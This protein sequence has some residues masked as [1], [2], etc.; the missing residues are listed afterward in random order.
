[1]RL[2]LLALC[3]TL[4]FSSVFADDLYRI[5]IGS[6]VDAVRLRQSD[7]EPVY[8]LHDGYLVVCDQIEAESLKASGLIVDLIERNVETE[9]L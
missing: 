4:S 1:M 3:V 7:A 2:L 8:R 5:S 9:E 6:E